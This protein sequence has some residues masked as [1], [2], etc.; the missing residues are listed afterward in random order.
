MGINAFVMGAA[1]CV[2]LPILVVFGSFLQPEPEIWQHMLE[3]LMFDLMINTGVLCIGVLAGTF[4]LGVGAAWLTASFEFPG[5]TIFNWALMLPLAVP[6]YVTAF[7][8]IGLLDFSGPVQTFLRERGI[9]SAHVFPNIRSAG[10]VIVVLSLALYPY[11]YLLARS[12][13][14]TQGKQILEVSRVL[15]HRPARAFFKSALPMARPWIAGGLTLVMM[16]TLADFGAVSIFNYDTFTTGIYKAWFGFFSLAAAAQLSSVL[17]LFVFLVIF[18]EQRMRRRMAFHRVGRSDINPGRIQ[19]GGSKKW[20]ACL[21]LTVTVLVA[22]FIPCL[23]L[24]LWSMTAVAAELEGRYIGLLIRSLLFS[25]MAVLVIVALGLM[26]SYVQRLH[27]D[28]F[29]A[30]VIRISTMGYA[31]PGTVLA[32]G[33]FIIIALVDRS[34]IWAVKGVSGVSMTAVL[35]GTI[36]PVLFA[37]TVRFLTLGY[38]SIHSGMLRIRKNLDETAILLGITGKRLLKTVHVP[39]LKNGIFTAAVLVF[40]DVMKEMPI[41][42]M[43]RP[44]GWDTLA[45]KIFELTSEGEWQRAALPSITLVLA[46][47]L[48]LVLLN[49][50]GKQSHL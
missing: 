6:T 28:P 4:V 33:I 14:E 17:L 25:G 11:V 2:L 29:T 43:T 46:G 44:F 27:P 24:F 10:G 13:F 36:L 15:G 31:F 47:L 16:E 45:V 35:N 12:A 22:F 50:S 18:V 48:P 23:Q 7:V 5:R 30:W 38:N 37:Y 20:M 40:V 32:V 42:L 26:M 1:L 39:M 8:F 49:R 3:T 41:T 34:L 9:V 21:F 19:L